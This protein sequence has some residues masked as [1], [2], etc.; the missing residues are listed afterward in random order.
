MWATLNVYTGC[1]WH[2]VKKS[3]GN[4]TSKNSKESSYKYMAENIY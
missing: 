2:G 1:H 3:G 4:S